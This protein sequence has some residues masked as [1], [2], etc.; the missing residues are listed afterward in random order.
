MEPME[1][2]KKEQEEAATDVIANLM[3]DFDPTEFLHELETDIPIPPDATTV[4]VSP[5]PI[6]YWLCDARASPPVKKEPGDA[7]F[8]IFSLYDITIHPG[9]VR[10]LSTG[11]QLIIPSGYYCQIAPRSGL[12]ASYAIQ[13][14]AGVVDRSY[15]GPVCVVLFN[16]GTESIHLPAHSRIAQLLFIKI[17]ES[18]E[19]LPT[20]QPPSYNTSLRGTKGFGESTGL[21]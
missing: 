20:H 3:D 1:E 11:V 7:G 12:S 14:L 10:K 19:L 2:E 9:T 13:V 17:H 16:A 15:T 6:K 4:A 18:V 21:Y 5:P 8:D